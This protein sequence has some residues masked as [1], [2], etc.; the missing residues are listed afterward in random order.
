MAMKHYLLCGGGSSYERVLHGTLIEYTGNKYG[1]IKT[2]RTID[3]FLKCG[4]C[5]N[6]ICCGRWN[7]LQNIC[8]CLVEFVHPRQD[9]EVDGSVADFYDETSDQVGIDL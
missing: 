2:I 8:E 6:S 1:S 4:R 7:N 9:A 3:I 5:D